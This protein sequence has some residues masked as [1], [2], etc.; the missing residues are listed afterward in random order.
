MTDNYS[1]SQKLSVTIPTV[2]SG[3]KDENALDCLSVILGGDNNSVLYQNLV[4]SQRAIRANCFHATSELAGN[5]SFSITP[6]NT[7][8][9]AKMDEAVR[10]A[11]A[12]LARNGI[13]DDAVE[14]FKQSQEAATIYGLESVSGKVSRLAYNQT[15]FGDA[16]KIVSDM[17]ELR[18]LTKQDVIDAYNKYVATAHLLVV[19]VLTKDKTSGPAGTDNYTVDESKNTFAITDYNGLKYNKATDN[20]DRSKMPNAG[21][22]PT[23]KLPAITTINDATNK[24][25]IL[26]SKSTEIPVVVANISLPGGSKIDQKDLTKLGLTNMFLRMMDE[27][28]KKHTAEEYSVL[29]DKLG[30][31]ISVGGSDYFYTIT[32]KCLKKNF[33]ESIQLLEERILQ[34]KFTEENLERFK[35]QLK[36]NIKNSKSN[37]EYLA[38]LAF[39]KQLYTDKSVDGLPGNGTEKTIDAIT[40]EDVTNYYNNLYK[41]GA[42][43]TVVGDVENDFV[44]KIQNIVNQLPTNNKPSV[45]TTSATAPIT[46]N[47]IY[48]INV[49]K[50]AQSQI[51]VGK[52]SNLKYDATGNFYK[53]G[54]S[55]FAL[56]GAFN[57]R[58]NLNLREKNGWTYGARSNFS[59][60]LT[61]GT[62][63][64]SSGVRTNATDSSMVELAKEI[65]NYNKNGITA[66]EVS[67]MKNAISQSD[68]RKYETLGQKAGLLNNMLTYDLSPKYTEEQKKVLNAFTKKD[69]DALAKKYYNMDQMLI[70]IA[71]DKEKIQP[72]LEKLGY[73]II[74]INTDSLLQ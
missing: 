24:T 48:L 35:M 41:T 18:K 39:N 32:L 9:L 38:N 49:P 66:E 14:K 5:L 8:S 31:E 20:F 67:F 6:A 59:S 3:H 17:A 50:A 15:F 74:E 26:V 13:T 60:G 1:K 54:L 57:S 73:K 43:I 61:N 33:N 37:A 56:G 28:T 53:A 30:T 70:V 21:A 7:E 51:R 64:F 46:S 27:D 10:E 16:N 65:S 72:G 45:K 63:L 42:Q 55:N 12:G 68:A 25:K 22:N 23:I 29:L 4:K 40:L 47:T 44:T 34:P 69:I 71:G 2:P 19:N 58:I 62:W 52:N 36:S 11:I